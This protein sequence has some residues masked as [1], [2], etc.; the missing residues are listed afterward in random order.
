MRN[1]ILAIYLCSIIC[2]SAYAD[3][4]G[5]VCHKCEKIRE[6]NAAHP[7]NNYYWYDDYLNEKKDGNTKPAPKPQ[8]SN[9]PPA[10]KK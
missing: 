9:T 7:E 6:Y 8:Q 5:P 1:K 10:T 2:G 4:E 3:D